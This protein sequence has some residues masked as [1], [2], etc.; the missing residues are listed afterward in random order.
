MNRYALS[1][2]ALAALSGCAGKRAI[3][4][5]ELAVLRDPNQAEAWVVLGDTY[6]RANRDAEAATAYGRAMALSP[7][8]PEIQRRAGGGRSSEIRELERQ[9]LASPEND[10]LWGDLGDLYAA[11]GDRE[12]ALHHYRYAM[13][14]DPDDGEWQRKVMEFA[15]PEDLDAMVASMASSRDDERIGDLADALLERGD[16]DAA[17]ALYFQ[18]L[19]IDPDDSEWIRKASECPGGEDIALRVLEAAIA[20]GDDERIGDAADVLRERGETERACELYMRALEID[21]ADS[22]WI[23]NVAACPGGADVMGRVLDRA[24]ASRDDERI[25]DVADWYRAQGEVDRACELYRR[26]AEI[27][28]G[29][30]EWQG[31]LE[32]CRTGNWDTDFEPFEGRAPTFPGEL[33][34]IE[35]GVLGGVGDGQ[36]GLGLAA[37]A[38]G[39]RTSA[40]EHFEAALL[41]SPGDREARTGVMALTGKSLVVLLEELTGRRPQDD[42]LW[43]DLA[44]A[45]LEVGNTTEALR[46]YRR[47]AEIDPDDSEWQRKLSILDPA[48]QGNPGR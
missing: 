40:L 4:N 29:D 19:E 39:D 11:A 18:A 13:S 36:T 14:L 26:A 1:L 43:G 46:A 34:G 31:N 21:P 8:N 3:E 12:T 48:R 22:E 6:R 35:G 42:E 37:L 24:I 10:E 38:R 23:R 2:V 41:D 25:G 45:Y 7:E 20:S 15:G 32:R 30:N 27:D 9:V 5:A 44:D 16:R 17:C 47:A 28:P 33:G